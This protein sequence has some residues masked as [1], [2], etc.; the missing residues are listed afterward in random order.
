MEELK[1]NGYVVLHCSEIT[2][3]GIMEYYMNLNKSMGDVQPADYNKYDN[4]RNEWV[5]VKYDIEYPS[6][7]PWN[8]NNYVK[9]HTDNTITPHYAN[10]TQLVCL[11]PAQYG[12]STCLI[13]NKEVVDILKY[14]DE[15]VS[16]NLYQ[17]ILDFE[18]NFPTKR[19][20]LQIK[21]GEYIFCFNSTQAMKSE[22][23]EESRQIIID[24]DFF[25]QKIMSNPM[26]EI[27]L[28]RGDALIFDDEKF[29]HGRRS[30]FGSRHLVKCGILT[31]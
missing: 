19:K 8:S 10:L 14:H 22:N 3:D 24:F 25:L 16:G 20:I 7:K 4:I 1:N 26:I 21:N 15:Y 11:K 29:L 18:I 9:L 27:K 13:P 28:N 6:D 2:D 5:D 30:F 17:K 31:T 12:G 23:T